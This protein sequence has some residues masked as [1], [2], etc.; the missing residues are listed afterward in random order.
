RRRGSLLGRVQIKKAAAP[1][2]TA[3][4]CASSQATRRG[5]SVVRLPTR[6]FALQPRNLGLCVAHIR[7][8]RRLGGCAQRDEQSISADRALAITHQR[9]EPTLLAQHRRPAEQRAIE[10]RPPP[11][12]IQRPP[13]VPE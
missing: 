2:A 6:A 8:E 13:L 5:R 9:R 7:L 12:C 1:L 3:R 10:D 11:C 4:F